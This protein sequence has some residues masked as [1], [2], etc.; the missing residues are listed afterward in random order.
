MEIKTCKES[1]QSVN[2]VRTKE[3]M[4]SIILTM[5]RYNFNVYEKRILYRLIELAQSEMLGL[6][7]EDGSGLVKVVHGL[8]NYKEI[9]LPIRSILGNEDDKNHARIKKAVF[10]LSK[11]SFIYEDDKTIEQ[12]NIVLSPKIYKGS[13]MITFIIEPK[14]WDC[15]LDFTRGYK[16]YELKTAMSFK[17]VYSMRFYELFSGQVDP[18]TISIE[19]LKE[20][21]GLVG[22]YP[23]FA[24]FVKRVI[25]PAK[26]E[27]DEH[28]PYSFDWHP[29][30]ESKIGKKIVNLT[31]IPYKVVKNE[32]TEIEHNKLKMQVSTS[33]VMDKKLRAYLIETWGFTEQELRANIDN[34]R[35]LNLLPDPLLF[36]SDLRGNARAAKRPKAYIIGAIKKA[37]QVH[38]NKANGAVESLAKSILK[39]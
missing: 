9:T 6:N 26:K 14:I 4:Q 21:F 18:L 34:L 15:C 11:K 5:A 28:S 36:L 32:N 31:F 38:R 29:H 23:N 13:S 10:G 24:H 22:C 20:M 7:F 25:E 27:L 3:Q 35:D 8:S 37:V 2:I 1:K 16:K 17:C 12:I 33:L 19:R 30:E 39:K